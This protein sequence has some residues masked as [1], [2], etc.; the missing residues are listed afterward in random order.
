MKNLLVYKTETGEGLRILSGRSNI[1]R[2]LSTLS[3]GE[4]YCYTNSAN[5]KVVVNPDGEIV[6]ADKGEVLSPKRIKWL[7]RKAYQQEA[8]PLFFKA[9]RGEATMEEYLTKV[10][11]IKERIK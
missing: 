7:R 8:D 5:V 2:A 6:E 3:E 11:E 4:S 1:E 10:R 9:Q